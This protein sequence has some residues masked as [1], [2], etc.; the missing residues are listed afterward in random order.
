MNEELKIIISAVTAEAQKEIEK[1]KNELNQTSK[2]TSSFGKKFGSVMKE[3]GKVAATAM[4][5]VVK[6]FV[7]VASGLAA[8]SVA[9]LKSY[10]EYEQLTGGVEKLFGESSKLVQEYA[11]NAYETAGISA[12]EYMEQ[13]T[14]F[15]ASLI[16]S[17]DGDTQKAAKSADMAIS[18]MADNAATFGTAIESI[19]NAYQGFAKQNYTMLDN[20]KLGYGGTKEEMQRLLE[21]AEKLSGI[22]YDISSLDDVYNAIHVIQEEMHITG[23]VATEGAT[24]IEGAIGRISASWENLLTGFVGGDVDLS[25]LIDNFVNSITNA[26]DLIVP[27]IV[28][29]LPRIA[30][31]LAQL[32]DG[33]IGEIPNLLNTLVPALVSA[34]TSVVQS[35]AD[36]LPDIIKSILDV[37]PILIQGIVDTS[38]IIIKALPDIVKTICEALPTLIPALIDGITEVVVCLCESFSDIIQPIIDNLPEIIISIVESL[39]NNLPLLIEGIIQL[40]IGIVEAIPQII[41][42]LI[43]AIPT[44]IALIIEAVIK[45]I[46]Q[47]LEGIGRVLLSIVT[48]LVEFAANLGSQIG[49][50]C[51]GIWDFICDIFSNVGSWFY[52]NVIVPIAEFMTELINSI[53]DWFSS[54]WNSICD[55]FSAIGDWFYDNVIA[56]IVNFFS[57]A[58]A[59]IKGFFTSI[60]EGIKHGIETAINGVISGFESFLNWIIGGING[61]IGGVNKVIGAVGDLFGANISIG[62]IGEVSFGRVALAKGG[63]VDKPTNALIGE[64]GTEAVIP[65]ENN[66]GW[67]DK[68]A[69]VLSDRLFGTDNR[70]PIILQVDGKTFAETSVDAINLLTRQTGNLALRLY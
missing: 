7:A 69:D 52:D 22:K 43:E 27:K 28:E 12:N 24:T 10:A 44:I 56:P 11:Q 41:M 31:G 61:L 8:M 46:P 62:L 15:S 17:L 14:S 48:S 26:S 51:S 4:K 60:W 58:V 57:E 47:I 42:A 70:V 49:E 13:V 36:A 67:L 20:L 25:T 68:F 63:I 54:I 50:W 55:C 16:S 6:G 2:E 18:D 38:K 59:T 66:L 29:A 3:I 21:D 65:L 53:G 35:L 34:V 32:I 5:A 19:Q 1:I 23:T 64:A 9:A 39:M 45:A 33:L 40:V 30:E 37:A